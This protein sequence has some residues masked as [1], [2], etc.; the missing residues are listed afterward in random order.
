MSKDRV[1]AIAN[2]RGGWMC[3]WCY[4]DRRYMYGGAG[5]FEVTLQNSLECCDALDK[6][7]EMC[8]QDIDNGGG[9]F[10]KAHWQCGE[11]DVYK[12]DGDS[13]SMIVNKRRILCC[14]DK[15][16]A[17]AIVKATRAA[18]AKADKEY[19]KEMATWLG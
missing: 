16:Q 15:D 5:S 6:A 18:S 9:Y 11:I 19:E 17:K 13:I 1:K 10:K 7:I 8:N 4:V 14:I 3:A 2:T 12:N